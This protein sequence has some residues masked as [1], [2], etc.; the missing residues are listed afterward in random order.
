MPVIVRAATSAL[1][2]ASSVACAVAS[3]IGS[4]AALASGAIALG[5]PCSAW[6]TSSA[7]VEKL[8]IRSPD[9]LPA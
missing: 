7:A 4:I 5:L 6:F 9:A 2:I 1:T 3:K 8:T